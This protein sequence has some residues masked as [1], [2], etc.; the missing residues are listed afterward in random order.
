MAAT[1][2]LLS[3]AGRRPMAPTF[4]HVV[5]VEGDA[6]YPTG[7]Y[8]LDLDAL[9]V[10]G[11]VINAFGDIDFANGWYPIFVRSTN[12]VKLLVVS[13]GAEVGPGTDVQ[14]LDVEIVLI[15]Q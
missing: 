10:K 8:L 1:I 12:K 5:R 3:E 13:T 14:A 7:G 2:T 9:G 4:V 6:S 11:T 15:S